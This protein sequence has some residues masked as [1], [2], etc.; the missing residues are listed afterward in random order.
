MLLQLNN[1]DDEFYRLRDDQQCL[2]IW[3]AKLIGLK[4]PTELEK[5][6]KYKQEPHGLARWL[7]TACGYLRIYGTTCDTDLLSSTQ[8]QDLKMICQFIISVYTP[9]WLNIFYNPEITEGPQIMLNIRDYILQA[10]EIFFIPISIMERMKKIYVVHGMAWLGEENAALSV[11]SPNNS[12]TIQSI[13]SVQ[14]TLNDTTRRNRLWDKNYHLEDFL[15]VDSIN[16]PCLSE[17][18]IDFNFW[19]ITM[20][21][22]RSCERYIGRMKNIIEGKQIVEDENTDERIKSMINLQDQT[23]LG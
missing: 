17:D 10:G 1:D 19:K 12:L 9:A 16:A 7:T 4:I 22:N 18:I 20:N 13:K 11:L 3:S 2:L 5:F 8:R 15:T 14:Q 21:S 6:L 23:K